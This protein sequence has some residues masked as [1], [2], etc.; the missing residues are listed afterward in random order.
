MQILIFG[1]GNEIRYQF[2]YED[3]YYLKQKITQ[4]QFLSGIVRK[5]VIYHD[6]D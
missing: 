1:I 6:L 3:H 4:S 2:Q 5:I